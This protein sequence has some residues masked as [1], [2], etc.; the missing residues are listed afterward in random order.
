VPVVSATVRGAR[1]I[2]R[3]AD[4]LPEPFEF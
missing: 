2:Y 1:K 3:M 4:L